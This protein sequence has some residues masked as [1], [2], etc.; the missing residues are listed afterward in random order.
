M[1][2]YVS[3]V[4]KVRE[5]LSL[6]IALSRFLDIKSSNKLTRYS[7]SYIFEY[8]KKNFEALRTI[9]TRLNKI[10]TR[11]RYRIYSAKVFKN[12]TILLT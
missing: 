10:K 7:S 8:L 12:I 5:N 4:I 9:L 3:R 11:R 1:S 2:R 6:L